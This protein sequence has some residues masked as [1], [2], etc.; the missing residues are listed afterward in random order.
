MNKKGFTLIELMAVIVILSFVAT[1]TLV[2]IIKI[3][4][5]KEE[6]NIATKNNIIT[7][8][9][10]LYIE[11]DNQKTLKETCM[12]IGCEISTSTLISAGILDS[13]DVDDE[14]I[15]KISKVNNEKKCTIK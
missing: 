11:L 7:T 9:A 5:K 4:N 2:N 3:F 6:Q 8:A 12:N 10:C 13:K 14:I 15:V 1:I